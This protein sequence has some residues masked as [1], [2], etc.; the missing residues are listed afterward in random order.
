LL[1]KRREKIR[2]VSGTISIATREESKDLPVREELETFIQVDSLRV[3]KYNKAKDAAEQAKIFT[4]KL[5]DEA[6]QASKLSEETVPVVKRVLKVCIQ[7]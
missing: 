4:H 6:L 5:A 1:Q 2:R 7:Y 3:V